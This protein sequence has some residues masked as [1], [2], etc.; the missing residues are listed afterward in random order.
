MGELSRWL[1]LDEEDRILEE[2]VIGMEEEER[3]VSGEGE[4]SSQ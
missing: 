1:F 4:E 2:V 3:E